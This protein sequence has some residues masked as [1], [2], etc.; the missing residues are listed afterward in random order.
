MQ[1]P[2]PILRC[3]ENE[4]EDEGEV[5]DTIKQPCS[6]RTI[7]YEKVFS[8]QLFCFMVESTDEGKRSLAK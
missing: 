2:A 6:G 5:K 3:D 4:N 8:G 7:P 1:G